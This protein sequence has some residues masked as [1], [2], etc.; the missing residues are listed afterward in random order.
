MVGMLDFIGKVATKISSMALDVSDVFYR[1]ILQD[2][3]KKDHWLFITIRKIFIYNCTCILKFGK[4]PFT[5][6]WK[7]SQGL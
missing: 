6:T 1:D 7:F 2:Y 4:H 3:I 5:L